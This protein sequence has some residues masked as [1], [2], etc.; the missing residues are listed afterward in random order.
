MTSIE[1]NSAI[2]KILRLSGGRGRESKYMYSVVSHDQTSFR[3]EGRGLG[4][5]HRAVC[6]PTLWSA[7]QSQRSIQSQYLRYV[8]NGNIQDFSLRG[9][10]T[11]KHEKLTERELSSVIS[12]NTNQN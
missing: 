3:T 1:K 7:Y 2:N 12:W 6:R 8:I 10:S 4:H 5:G 9:E 11:L